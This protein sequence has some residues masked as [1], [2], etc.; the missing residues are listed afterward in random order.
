MLSAYGIMG[1]MLLVGRLL[2]DRK[3]KYYLRMTG[4]CYMVFLNITQAVF[5]EEIWFNFYFIVFAAF[6]I[7]LAYHDFKI[8]K[9]FDLEFARIDRKTKESE[10]EIAEYFYN[11]RN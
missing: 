9:F 6:W 3:N 2:K 4:C 7:F 8:T 1:I 10:K 11:K 5:E